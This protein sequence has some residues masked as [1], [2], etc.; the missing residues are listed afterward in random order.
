MV[1][2]SITELILQLLSVEDR[3]L[4]HYTRRPLPNIWRLLHALLSRYSKGQGASVLDLETGTGRSWL[5]SRWRRSFGSHNLRGGIGFHREHG[6][7]LGF[8]RAEG[9]RSAVWLMRIIHNRN[10]MDHITK[11]SSAELKNRDAHSI[12]WFGSR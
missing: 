2:P 4:G 9:R 5:S 1:V 12:A 8:F 11:S 6:S 3:Y 10:F 7:R